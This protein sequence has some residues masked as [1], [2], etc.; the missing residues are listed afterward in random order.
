MIR[1]GRCHQSSEGERKNAYRKDNSDGHVCSSI[2]PNDGCSCTAVAS[3]GL[4]RRIAV[5][6]QQSESLG[7][8][9]GLR[10][11]CVELVAGGALSG[12]E[13]TVVG[14]M[15]QSCRSLEATGSS[16][17]AGVD[18]DGETA[19]ESHSTKTSDR[20]L[21]RQWIATMAEISTDEHRKRNNASR[22]WGM[23]SHDVLL[24]RVTTYIFSG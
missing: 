6:W 19:Q 3:V 20:N 15:E 5:D 23:I 9:L 21:R 1:D 24:Q 10:Y 18:V 2:G 16:K 12:K 11:V 14:R 7:Q 4:A 22:T 13:E 8:Q 17:T